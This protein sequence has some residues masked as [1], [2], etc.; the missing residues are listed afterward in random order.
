MTDRKYPDHSPMSI[1]Q[2]MAGADSNFGKILQRA[3]ALDQL[4]QRVSA[5]LGDDL[6]K[7]C[8]LANVRDGK[9]IFACD[10]PGFAT[11]LKLQSNHLL[12]LLEK[13]GLEGVESIEVR[14][15]L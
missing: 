7:H 3:R 1:A 2:L 10:S 5:L 12:E 9:M 15:V 11:R 13:A 4:G 6:S 8:R 14:L